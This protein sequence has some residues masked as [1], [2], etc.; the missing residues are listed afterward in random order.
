MP[1]EFRRDIER[2]MKGLADE[3]PSAGQ[4]LQDI[5]SCLDRSS[6]EGP[7]LKPRLRSTPPHDRRVGQRHRMRSA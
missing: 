5:A 3:P 2:I 7:S 6:R 4:V 1:D